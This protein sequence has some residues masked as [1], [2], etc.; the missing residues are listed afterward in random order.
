MRTSERPAGAAGAEPSPPA[1]TV[2][3]VRAPRRTATWRWIHWIQFV[4]ILVCAFT[5]FYIADPFFAAR[6]AYLMSWMLAVHLYGALVLDVS[7]FVVVYLYFFSRADRGIEQL[8]PTRRNLVAF[9]EAFLNLVTVG[10]RKRFDTSRPDPL[11][12]VWFVLLHVLIVVQLFTGLQL[13]VE[14]LTHH[15]SS[16]GTWW[17]ELLHFVTDWTLPVMGGNVGVRMVHYAVMWFIITWA[18][19]HVYYEWWRTIVW[20]E[21]DIGIMFGG[22][23]YVTRPADSDGKGAGRVA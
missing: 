23:K 10:R 19:L 3:Y 16:V 4:S 8:L 22:Y 15:Q 14:S 17:P 6:V 7:M 12:A 2:R 20:K 21:G 9:K 18:V 13:Y 5:G 11:N 1:V